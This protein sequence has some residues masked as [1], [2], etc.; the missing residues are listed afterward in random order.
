[1]DDSA[2]TIPLFPLGTVLYPGGVLPLR[3]FEPRYVAMVRDCLARE[4]AFG[5]CLIRAGFEAGTPAIPHGTGCTARIVRCE[6]TGPD[7]FSLVARGESV[8]RIDRHWARDDDLLMGVVTLADPPDPTPLPERFRGLRELLERAIA[9]HG[10]ERFPS[11][12][13]LDD[14]AWVAFRVAELLPVPPERRQRF[15]TCDDPI[16]RLADVA[17]TLA[18]LRSGGS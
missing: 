17:E 3:I 1:M 6:E 16:A 4:S 15:L 11:P 2:L 14:A 12:T 7:R 18:E 13:R 5:V 9:E 8:F 10:A